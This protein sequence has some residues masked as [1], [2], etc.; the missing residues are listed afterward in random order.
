MP[1]VAFNEASGDPALQAR[2]LIELGVGQQVSG[3]TRRGLR[4][5]RR[6]AQRAADAGD[7]SVLARALTFRASIELECEPALAADTIAAAMR[8][9]DGS[10]DE[11]N[12]AF[13]VAAIKAVYD[14]E[15]LDAVRGSFADLIDSALR[16]GRDN[17]ALAL[18]A[19]L[20]GLELRAG[21]LGAAESLAA[22]YARHTQGPYAASMACYRQALVA[23]Y[24]GE[25]ERATRL[26]RHGLEIGRR[27]QEWHFGTLHNRE[28]LSLAAAITADHTGVL[29]AL[30]GVADYL[31]AAEICNPGIFLYQGNELEALIATG[32]HP[33][34]R[35]RID[36]LEAQGAATGQRRALGTAARARGALAA[37]DRDADTAVS[38]FERAIELHA[39]P[40]DPLERGRTLR[41][42]PALR[43]AA[44][45]S[46][47][48]PVSTWP[49]RSRPSTT[50]EPRGGAIERGRSWSAFPAVARSRAVR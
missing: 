47:D 14:D 38:E 31:D 5:Y 45:T 11:Y 2:I 18:T 40:F 44:S 39:P 12:S 48:A 22:R 19:N 17:A 35:R 49:P 8:E 13:G 4:L 33:T 24:M 43:C 41:W 30:A 27:L 50:W 25:Q 26:A 37:E 9:D 21:R 34:A 15:G 23:G 36:R 28:A 1:V 3:N 32:D 42:P 7:R 6:A 10:V 29:E 20:S 46:A 16:S